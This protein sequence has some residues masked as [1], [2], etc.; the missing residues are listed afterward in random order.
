MPIISDKVLIGI[1]GATISYYENLGYKIPKGTY[2]GKEV[3]KKGTRIEVDVKDLKPCSVAKVKVKC[4]KC[5]KEYETTYYSYHSCNKDGKIFCKHCN[6]LKGSKNGNYNPNKTDEERMK[7]RHTEKDYIFI[8]KVLARDNYTCQCCGSHND[9]IVHHLE[10]Y[11][12]CK[13]KRYDESNGITLCKTCHDNFHFEY[14]RGN[15]TKKQFEKWMGHT[16]EI[17]ESNNKIDNLSKVICLNT[18]K[19]YN[20]IAEANREYGKKSNNS[21]I[22]RNCKGG[23]KYAFSIDNTVPVVFKYYND[24]LKMSKSEIKKALNVE[25]KSYKKIICL[26]TG[27]IF[28]TIK[29]AEQKYNINLGHLNQH[30]KGIRKSCGIYKNQKLIWKLYSD[31]LKEQ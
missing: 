5:G 30:L 24:Y 9:M 22:V 31:Y 6:G 20:T 11:N 8:K 21:Q 12:W 25:L 10:G 3:V 7:N 17:L 26:T 15:N 29:E 19:I 23:S 4:D 14:G 18:L 2:R 1:T 27:D 13:N 28:N 16:I